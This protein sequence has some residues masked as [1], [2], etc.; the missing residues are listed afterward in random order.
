MSNRVNLELVDSYIS[1]L[2]RNHI[3]PPHINNPKELV[4]DVTGNRRPPRPLNSFLILRKNVAE[5]I[6]RFIDRPN[7]RVISKVSSVLWSA[8]TKEEKDIYYRLAQDVNKLH[9]IKYPNFRYTLPRRQ[10]S[11]RPYPNPTPLPL[12]ESE[13]IPRPSSTPT[14]VP[15]GITRELM[16]PPPS[17]PNALVPSGELPTDYIPVNLFEPETF[18]IM[19]LDGKL[20]QCVPVN[21]TQ[22]Y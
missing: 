7:M 1:L 12:P 22:M 10:L 5:E 4:P 11:F 8:S 17:P 18:T 14:F 15:V 20:Y 3:F 6:R 13:F 9:A 2:N 16:T 21:I 19:G